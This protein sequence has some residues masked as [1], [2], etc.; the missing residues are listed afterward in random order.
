MKQ[1]LKLMRVKHYIKNL[2]IFLPLIF[3]NNMTNINLLIKTFLAFIIFSL[4]TSVV[5]IFNDLRDIEKD[6]LHPT[7]KFRP[8]ASGKITKVQAYF[9]IIILLGICTISS[10]WV[11]KENLK[12]YLLILVYIVLNICYSLKLKDIPIIDITILAIGYLLRIMYGASII[13]VPVSNW[14]Y[15]TILSIAF[16]MG[17]GKRRNEIPQ[18]T[19]ND[20]TREV[21]KY[22]NT[23]FLDKNMYMC[24]GL[25][26]VFYSLWC[27]D[28]SSHINNRIN[29]MYTIPLVIILSMKYSLNI[30]KEGS[31]DPVEVILKDKI[32]I[33]LCF[34]LAIMLGVNYI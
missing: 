21:L 17:M 24:L 31:G 20:T 34:I 7:K 30:E 6:K 18:T 3:S 10:I 9:I 11:L 14:L 28:I 33:A 29:I 32:I 16:Y 26:I 27:I 4:I 23:N 15:L 25:S 5:Y 12:A 13:Y 19:L 1:V 22:Y 8:L 2:L